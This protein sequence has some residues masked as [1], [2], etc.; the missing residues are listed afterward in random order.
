MFGFSFNSNNLHVYLFIYFILSSN[1]N[2]SLP[3]IIKPTGK[4]DKILLSFFFKGLDFAPW[5]LLFF[6]YSSIL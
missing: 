3:I 6:K 4:F 1:F 2:D 5:A